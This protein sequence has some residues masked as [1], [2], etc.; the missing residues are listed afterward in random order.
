MQLLSASSC[1]DCKVQEIWDSTCVISDIRFIWNFTLIV[2]SPNEAP[3]R[4]AKPEADVPR[5]DVIPR[6]G[7]TSPVQNGL[8]HSPPGGKSQHQNRLTHSTYVSLRNSLILGGGTAVWFDKQSGVWLTP[9]VWAPSF[10]KVA[11]IF[12][13]LLCHYLARARYIKYIYYMA[14]LKSIFFLYL[15]SQMQRGPQQ[16]AH[17]L[18]RIKRWSNPTPPPHP[19]PQ[20]PS[21]TLPKMPLPPRHNPR[22]RRANSLPNHSRNPHRTLRTPPP[23]PPSNPTSFYNHPSHTWC[24]RVLGRR[25]GVL[26][27]FF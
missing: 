20:S 22:H 1:G 14:I 12:C 27:R 23:L 24:P 25:W 13:P 15:L 10:E 9:P 8:P 2:F 17:L 3:A 5:R 26:Y 6:D 19:L 21:Q 7:A 16:P 4:K 11:K 18:P